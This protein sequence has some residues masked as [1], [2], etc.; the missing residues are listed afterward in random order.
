MLPC[1]CG[2][3]ASPYSSPARLMFVVTRSSLF[4]TPTSS[5]W[6]TYGFTGG[7]GWPDGAMSVVEGHGIRG[8]YE[9]STLIPFGCGKG[10][11][12]QQEALG[13]WGSGCR[14]SRAR[15]F[16]YT[17]RGNPQPDWDMPFSP[18]LLTFLSTDLGAP[19]AMHE[20][21]PDGHN[22]ACT[23]ARRYDFRALGRSCVSGLVHLRAA[24]KKKEPAEL[25]SR[26]GFDTGFLTQPASA[27]SNRLLIPRLATSLLKIGLA[28]MAN[29]LPRVDLGRG[30]D[31]AA[32]Y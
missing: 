14:R 20:W 12:V 24:I 13:Q 31:K 9:Q 23:Y 17:C 4:Y 18:G 29:P 27:S 3:M 1:G 7:V 26:G 19:I 25:I 8:R 22:N 21:K 2:S 28:E 16:S 30:V 15:L 11:R 6:G 32:H 5:R 10:V